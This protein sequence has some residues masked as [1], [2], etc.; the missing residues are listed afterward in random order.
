METNLVTGRAPP[1]DAACGPVK[2]GVMALQPRIPKDHGNTW[3]LF[4]RQEHVDQNSL[5]TDGPQKMAVQ[6]FNCKWTGE[7]NM[8]YPIPSC[9][10][11]PSS[12]MLASAPESMKVDREWRE[13]GGKA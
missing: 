6:G 12:M 2:V 9:K 8:T 4:A 5:M 7:R 3:K 1:K 10:A 11:S 13:P